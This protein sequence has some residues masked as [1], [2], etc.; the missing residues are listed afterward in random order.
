MTPCSCLSRN[1]ECD[2]TCGCAAKEGETSACLNR[3]ITH[4]A[5]VKLGEDV[6]EINSWGMDCYTRRNIQDAVLESQAFG[7]YEMPNFKAILAKLKAGVPPSR[8]A[9]TAAGQHAAAAVQK[10]QQHLE[11]RVEVVALVDQR[12]MEEEVPQRM[13]QMVPMLLNPRQKL[14]VQSQIGL[15]ALLCL[16]LIVKDLMDGIFVLV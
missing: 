8:A 3:A 11:E 6:E 10:Q 9:A 15:N 12:K 4:R 7:A 2:D 13:P 1:T 5:T 16:L 14:S